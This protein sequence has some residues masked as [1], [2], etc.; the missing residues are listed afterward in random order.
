MKSYSVYNYLLLSIVL[1]CCQACNK[2][3]ETKP[4]TKLAIPN[5][6]E[7]CQ[8]LLDG[9]S[10]VNMGYPY[11]GELCT[12]NFSIATDIWASISDYEDRMLYI[13]DDKITPP[14]AQWASPYQTVYIANQV[15][16]ILENLPEGPRRKQMEGAAYFY[17]AYALFSLAEIFAP[18]LLKDGSNA[19]VTALPYRTS[20]NVEDKSVRIPLGEFFSKLISDL[21]HAEKLLQ[22][23]NG[24]PSRPNSI[25]VVA[26]LSRI[27]LYLQDYEKALTYTTKALELNNALVD[28]NT[29]QVDEESPFKQFNDEVIFQAIS[30]GSFTFYRTIW[31]VDP[32]LY[33]SYADNDLRKYLL[34]MDNGDNTFSFKGNYDGE[35]NQSPFS[36]LAVDEL[37]LTQAECLVRLK[38]FDKAKESINYLCEKRYKKGTFQP[39]VTSDPDL[40]LK[41]ILEERRKELIMRQRRW[42][43]LK[44]L[45]LA[46]KTATTLTRTIAG[47]QYQLLPN[48]GFYTMLIPLEIISNSS[49]PQTE[50]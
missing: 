2:F 27:Y 10:T 1:F 6:F 9:Y 44:R 26:L 37:V 7:D 15:L 18:V 41:E 33:E 22:Q 46:P 43:D 20:P 29:L 8:A 5:T 42:P 21:E 34:F 17:R 25:A 38:E 4:D 32:Q 31:K 13:W 28:Y 3:L 11:V 35:L 40:L 48:S 45:N 47:K 49:L 36:G 23:S 50:R 12:D 19:A 30:T 24:L 14:Q 16:S 39:I